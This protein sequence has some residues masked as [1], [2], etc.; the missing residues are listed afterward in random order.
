MR[1]V[2]WDMEVR[3]G[4]EKEA[5]GDLRSLLVKIHI[6]KHFA[7]LALPSFYL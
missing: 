4:K 7:S 1:E 6:K 2:R 5:Q 3:R